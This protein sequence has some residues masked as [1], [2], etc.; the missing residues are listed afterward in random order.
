MSRSF[1]HLPWIANRPDTR[2]PFRELFVGDARHLEVDVDALQ[3]GAADP[4]LRAA[5]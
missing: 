4:L 3:Q 1:H 5:D 2:Y